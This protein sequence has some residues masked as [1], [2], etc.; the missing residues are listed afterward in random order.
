[1]SEART[2]YHHS[3]IT[4]MDGR[5][6]PYTAR[7]TVETDRKSGKV[8]YRIHSQVLTDRHVPYL[9]TGNA[10]VDTDAIQKLC[11]RVYEFDRDF[12]PKPVPKSGGGKRRSR[13]V[14]TTKPEC[15]KCGGSGFTSDEYGDD[16]PCRC[17]Q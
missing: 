9:C 7:V 15:P 17:R 13:I 8:I 10:Q 6:E 5:K 12:G 16:H 14:Q 2:K 3:T 4:T 11:Q 1:M